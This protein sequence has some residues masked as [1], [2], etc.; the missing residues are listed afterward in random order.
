M[1]MIFGMLPVNEEQ[2]RALRADPETISALLDT[3]EGTYSLDKS[4]HGLHF[5]LTETAW[6]G[7][8]PL[9]FIVAGEEIGDIDVGYGPAKMFTNAEVRSIA[10]ALDELSNEHLRKRFDP[11]KMAALEIYPT[12]W[13]RPDDG[14]DSLGWLLAAMDEL[15]KNI[16][17]F[18][19]RGDGL[20]TFMQ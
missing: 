10:A 3:D 18:A 1:S 15:K 9:N 14:N 13:D 5:L 2:L 16:R 4:W 12:G 11:K 8:P 6:E 17:A 20:V 7:E 19:D